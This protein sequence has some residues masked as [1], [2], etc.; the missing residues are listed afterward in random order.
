MKKIESGRSMVE[1]L[2][3]LA[4]IGVLSIG[5]ISG[6]TLSMRRHR[7]NSVVDLA[8]KL[9]LTAYDFT[10]KKPFYYG[11]TGAYFFDFE[12]ADIGQLPAGV[13]TMGGNFTVDKDEND[14]DFV[15]FSAIFDDDK[16]CQTVGAIT[17]TG[18]DRDKRVRFRMKYE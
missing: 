17:G 11:N 6:Y 2:G 5:G 4:I 16:L 9:S 14:V 8:S 12:T 3:V 10:Q 1:M 13:I 18:C 15:E 7:A